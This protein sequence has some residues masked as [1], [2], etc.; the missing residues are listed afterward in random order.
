MKW[1]APA[2]WAF[3]RW[4]SRRRRPTASPYRPVGIYKADRLG[5]F[6]LALG[7]IRQ[8]VDREGTENC[9]LIIAP[10]AREIARHEFPEIEQAVVEPWHANLGALLRYCQ[11]HSNERI[12][13]EGVGKLICLR[14]NR[15]FSENVVC[16][17]IPA[18]ES[19]AVANSH[20]SR[21]PGQWISSKPWDHEFHRFESRNGETKDFSRHRAVLAGY[22]GCP[23]DTLDV[24]PRMTA[25]AMPLQ[26]HVVV[27]PFGS[28]VVRDFPVNLLAAAGRHV[29]NRFQW[30]LRLLSPPG[31]ETRYRDLIAQLGQLGVP[32]VE[33]STCRSISNLIDSIFESRLVLSVETATAHI[34]A[35]LDKPMVA[36]L[37]GGH[38]GWFA[39]W[40][41]TQRQEWVSHK[42]V[43]YH[44][45]WECIHPE[46]ICLT[47]IPEAELTASISAVLAAAI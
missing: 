41:R 37:G 33:L 30:R 40:R 15:L 39:P 38:Y 18:G 42:V 24:T 45:N 26:S 10:Y 14:H 27:S 28:A 23:A 8:I 31:D 2:K 29:W 22:F 32:A 20:L 9:V 1:N 46:P 6:V 12:F 5:D 17:R 34:A 13:A 25:R 7:A 11:T 36:L 44:C 19:W 43:C 35:A 47:R 3:Y 16:G 21:E 4:L